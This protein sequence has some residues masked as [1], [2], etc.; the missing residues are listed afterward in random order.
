MTSGSTAFTVSRAY[1]ALES[2][3]ENLPENCALVH[4]DF[5]ENFTCKY[6]KEITQIHFV[7]SNNKATLH[8]GII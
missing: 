3:K 4:V 6:A 8:G 5:S 7:A 2:L 1:R